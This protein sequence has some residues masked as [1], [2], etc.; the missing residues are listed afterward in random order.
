MA[1]LDQALLQMHEQ[2]WDDDRGMVRLYGLHLVRETA[3]GAFL[4]LENGRVERAT[5]ALREVLRHQ[6]PAT[7]DPRWAGTFATHAAQPTAG[8]VQDDGRIRDVE[9]RDYDPNWRQ[10]LAMILRVT[11]LLHGHVLDADLRGAMSRAVTGAVSHEPV[12]R[13]TSRY[14]NIALLHAWLS[15]SRTCL[16][17]TSPSPRD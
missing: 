13:I 5:R 12:G 14:S 16:L 3:L 11:E 4:D 15:D 10:F 8:S 6:Y 17:Y 9:W 7:S 2:L 1:A